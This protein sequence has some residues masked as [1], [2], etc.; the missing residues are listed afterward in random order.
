MPRSL[1]V[2]LRRLNG[3]RARRGFTVV[4]LLAVIGTITVLLG[5]LLAGLQ[6]ARRSGKGTVELNQLRQL[7]MASTTYTAGN[8]DRFMP[9]YL[10]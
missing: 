9:G 10:D 7:H 5:L 4:E 2:A 1:L 6:A 3:S 8:G